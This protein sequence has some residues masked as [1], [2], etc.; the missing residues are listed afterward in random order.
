MDK[1][2]DVNDTILIGNC[3]LCMKAQWGTVTGLAE[4]GKMLE[5]LP[6]PMGW[7]DCARCF[8]LPDDERTPEQIVEAAR[9]DDARILMRRQGTTRLSVTPDTI[10]ITHERKPDGSA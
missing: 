3:A 8:K 9:A 1:A 6:Y 10:T 5:V 4:G 7:P 2:T